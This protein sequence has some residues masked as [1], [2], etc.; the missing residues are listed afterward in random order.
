[1]D[2][3]RNYVRHH[4]LCEFLRGQTAAE[5]VRKISVH[6]P[7]EYISHSMAKYWYG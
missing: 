6:V 7:P 5:T 3:I 1:M 4:L 2:E